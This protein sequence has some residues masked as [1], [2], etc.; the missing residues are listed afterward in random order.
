MSLGYHP[1]SEE[2]KC[3]KWTH[4]ECGPTFATSPSPSRLGRS[5]D[6]CSYLAKAVQI[7][8]V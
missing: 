3:M 6:G 1:V 7:I 5:S 4:I 2:K 8:Q